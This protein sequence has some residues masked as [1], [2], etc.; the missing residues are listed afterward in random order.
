MDS[1]DIKHI[2]KIGLVV[3]TLAYI[4]SKIEKSKYIS[5]K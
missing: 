1:K 4:V 3:Y 2:S 5:S